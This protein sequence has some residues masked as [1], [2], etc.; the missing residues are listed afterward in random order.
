MDE[1][2]TED[3]KFSLNETTITAKPASSCGCS[4]VEGAMPK[5]AIARDF[6]LLTQGAA[7]VDFVSAAVM[8]GTTTYLP[9]RQSRHPGQHRAW[10]GAWKPS[11]SSSR[12]PPRGR[13]SSCWFQG[14]FQAGVR[15]LQYK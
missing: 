6:V 8:S 10:P 15:A 13:L 11:R 3:V 7:S 2:G 1:I 4:V 14:R 9:E 5:V 12:F